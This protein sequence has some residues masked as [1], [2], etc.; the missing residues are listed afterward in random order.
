M[1][2]NQDSTDLNSN[3][4]DRSKETGSPEESSNVIGL[5]VVEAKLR[6]RKLLWWLG[7][8]VAVVVAVMLILW[9]SPLLAVKNINVHGTSLTTAKAVTE[10][11]ESIKG[12]PLPQISSDRVLELLKDDPAVEDVVVQAQTPA[13]LDVQVIEYVPVAVMRDGSSQ[14]LV[15]SDGHALAPATEKNSESLPVIELANGSKDQDVFLAVTQVLGEITSE[16]RAELASATASS[17]DS[18][19]LKLND[20]R[21]IVWGSADEG[22]KKAA[23]LAALLTVDPEESGETIDVSSPDHPVTK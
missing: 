6:R 3:S 11:L 18:V 10:R 21:T 8:A 14:N 13:T 23:V 16:V 19:Q 15:A 5:P 7:G 22:S 17:I 4:L 1:A 20:G 2:K 12:T 9:F